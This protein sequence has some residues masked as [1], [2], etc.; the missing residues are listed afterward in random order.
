MVKGRYGVVTAARSPLPTIA[1]VIT[2]KDSAQR[3]SNPA[4]TAW[5]A[6]DRRDVAACDPAQGRR[7]TP[8]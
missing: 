7:E 2:D 6:A 1:D 3:E 4:T 8:A 5:R